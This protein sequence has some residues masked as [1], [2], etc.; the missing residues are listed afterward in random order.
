[1]NKSAVVENVA[2]ATDL[3]KRDA[4]AAVDAFIAAVIADTRAGNKVALFG[5]DSFAPT[6]RAIAASKGVKFSA[7]GQVG[8]ST[9]KR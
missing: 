2:A 3:E 5:F 7:G 6:S 1:M 9:K 8:Q 4:E